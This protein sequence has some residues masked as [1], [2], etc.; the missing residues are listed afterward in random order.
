MSFLKAYKI[1]PLRCLGWSFLILFLASCDNSKHVAGQTHKIH[2]VNTFPLS[3]VSLLDGPFKRANI[4]GQRTLLIYEPDRLLAKFRINAGLEPKVEHYKGWEDESLAGH[5]LGHY[6][7]ACNIM[8]QTTGNEEFLNRANY[9]VDALALCQESDG[10]GYIGAF[11]NGK[12]IFENE[13]AIGE[14]RS[15]GFNLNGIWA[16]FYTHHKVLAGL[17]DSYRLSGN[18]KALTV[19]RKFADWIYTIVSPLNDEQIQKMLHCEHGGMNEVLVDLYTDTGDKKY[20]LMANIFYHKAVLDNLSNQVDSLNGLHANT[21]FPKLIGL[22][23]RYD[24]LGN[25]KDS[26][27]ATFFWDRV[28]NH[29]SYVT[30]GNGNHEYFGKPDALSKRLSDETTETCNVYNMLKLSD[31]IFQ[32]TPSAEVADFYERALIN[33][34]LSSQ[35]PETGQVT[36][37]QS[38]EMGGF[39]LYQDPFGFTCCVG[40]GMENHAKYNAHIYYHDDEALFVSQFIA[41]ELDWKSKGVKVIQQTNFPEEQGT[42][43]EINTAGPTKFT[44]YIRYPYW[45]EKGMDISINGNKIENNNKPSSFVA[46]EREW[47]D[48]DKISVGL[49]FTKRL[50]FMPDDHKRL[51]MMYGPLVLAGELGEEDSENAQA[52]DFVPTFFSEE[53]NA[54]NW[55]AET[56]VANSFLTQNLGIDREIT[57]RPLYKMHNKRYSVYWDVFTHE[58][59]KSYQ[60]TLEAEQKTHDQLVEKTFDFVQPGEPQ[61]EQKHNYKGEDTYVVK[62]QDKEARQA[63]RGG[64]FSF[65]I[66]VV[67][68]SPNALVFEYWGGYTGS[69]TFDIQVDGTTIA[70]Q[71]ISGIKDGS[72]LTKQYDVPVELTQGKDKITVK[73]A[74]HEG[75]RG[76]PVF[77]IRTIKL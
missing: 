8:Y 39:K 36:Y 67:K 49:P 9:I 37:N 32:L 75:S 25:M 69:K 34:I 24:A 51:A 74:P 29:H 26:V 1:T 35:N 33:Q 5:S 65:D 7:S 22:V 72:F 63:E 12:E 21:Q 14:I 48:G 38:L 27:A 40:S 56:G 20:L 55:L 13:I 23:K 11:E 19:A 18:E 2:R 59:W 45:A 17:R 46:I 77:G 43:L 41:S 64:W 44:M 73:I 58:E 68:D 6:L 60:E 57:M 53:K 61:S 62:M 70:T 31:L 76:G 50:E 28:V 42:S 52:P 16:P 71:S 4:L 10:D 15:Q 30:G 54:R 3:D 47:K 66:K